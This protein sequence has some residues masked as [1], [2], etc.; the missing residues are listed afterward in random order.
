MKLAFII[1]CCSIFFACN[2]HPAKESLTI[3]NITPVATIKTASNPTSKSNNTMIADTNSVEEDGDNAD[4]YAD[5]YVVVA[6]TG[7]SY[8]VLRKEM[9]RLNKSLNIPIDTMGRTYN[10]T[11]DLIALSDNDEDE[12]YA[13]EYFPRRYPSDVLSLEYMSLYKVDT[14]EKTIALV[15]GIYQ[16]KASADS[17]L[18]TLTSSTNAFA[19]K[20]HIYVGCMH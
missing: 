15:T 20:A 14:D 3:N 11:K 19:V 6:D 17:A 2:T 12:I 16:T 10:K 18:S 4:A 5:Y 7:K 13:G 9:F 8:E 1:F